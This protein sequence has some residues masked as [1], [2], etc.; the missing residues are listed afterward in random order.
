MAD[1]LTND[2]NKEAV[3]NNEHELTKGHHTD[4]LNIKALPWNKAV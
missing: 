2:E 1:N 4:L 3:T